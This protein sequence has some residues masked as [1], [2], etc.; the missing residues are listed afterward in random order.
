MVDEVVVGPLLGTSLMEPEATLVCQSMCRHTHSELLGL[1]AE[2]PA[3]AD[4]VVVLHPLPLLSTESPTTEPEPTVNN[5]RTRRRH[6]HLEHLDAEPPALVDVVVVVVPLPPLPLLSTESSI[7]GPLWTKHRHRLL[8]SLLAEALALPWVDEVV[9]SLSKASLTKPKKTLASDNSSQSKCRHRHL[10]YRRGL[11]AE[12]PALALADAVVVVV[13]PLP[14]LSTESPLLELEALVSE[15]CQSRR[16]RRQH[17]EHLTVEPPVM[18]AVVVVV[19]LLSTEVATTKSTLDNN[20]SWLRRHHLLRFLLLDTALALAGGDVDAVVALPVATKLREATALL[21]PTLAIQVL[22]L[23]AA[24]VADLPLA[25][26]LHRL[27]LEAVVP[28]VVEAEDLVE[29][30]LPETTITILRVD[31]RLIPSAHVVVGVAV[32]H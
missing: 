26:T 25:P 10:E 24:A 30:R 12:L 3:L 8:G 23:V 17:L 20:R 16:R 21:E 13:P 19:S 7:T 9:W 14:L 31:P 18:D 15:I 27:E 1:D 28:L 5:N 6:R 29:M 4:A 11:D 32:L 2:L 22:L